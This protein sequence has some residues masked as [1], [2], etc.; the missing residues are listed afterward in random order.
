MALKK[1]A[2]KAGINREV[3]RY[4]NEAGWYE[5]DKVRFRQG[6]PEKIGG[7]ER[8][9]V[10]T[11]QGVCRS[12]SNWV[13]LASINLIGLGTHLKFYLEQ[14][15]GYNDITPIRETTAAG[16][17]T[18]AAT[19]GSASL[20]VTDNGHGARENDFVTFS[21]AVTL[22]G[23]ITANVLN[24]EYQIVTVPDANSYTITV[25]ATANASDTGN[26]G[27]HIRYVQVSL[28]KFL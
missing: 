15:G 11:F 13:T 12:L 8:I 3:T 6:Y 1:L 5:C 24:A 4:T 22:G 9:S 16:D 25:T 19:N 21:G 17:V 18:F 28:T 14:G 20:T 10:S 23:N 7:W 26:G 27:V 2:F